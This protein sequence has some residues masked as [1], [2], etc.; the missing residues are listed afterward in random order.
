MTSISNHK[1]RIKE[2]L[3]E[4]QDAINIGIY[5]R[6][7]TIGFHTTA[8]SIDML[9]MYLHKKK[10]ID[11]GKVVK[12]DWFKRPNK[13]QKKTPLIE[14]KLPV[15]FED[16]EK[17]YEL[18]YSLEENRDILIYGK[19]TKDQIEVV[20]KNFHKLKEIILE[21]LEEEGENFE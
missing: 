19:P 11:I 3:E 18:I 12:H 16:K 5:S 14:R 17:I 6:P 13:E 4:L 15:N 7:A 10:L 21:K 1:D 8:C 9:E 20:L 2:H